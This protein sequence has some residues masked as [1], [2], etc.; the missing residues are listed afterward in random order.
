MKKESKNKV[1]NLHIIQDPIKKIPHSKIKAFTSN[2]SRNQN[3]RRVQTKPNSSF[4]AKTNRNEEKKVIKKFNSFTKISPFINKNINSKKDKSPKNSNSNKKIFSFKKKSSNN[5]VNTTLSKNKENEILNINNSLEKNSKNVKVFI[6]FRPSNDV[7]DSL[8]KNN[9]G[10]LVPKYFSEKQLGIYPTQ[11][12]STTSQCTIPKNLIFSFDK[13]FSPTS[14]Q[15]EI[16]SSVG[17][18]IVEDIMAGYNGTI[19]TYGQSGSGKTYT[20]YGE[21]IFNEN[22]KG[23]I[24]RIVSEI[25]NRMEK[26]EGDVDFTIKLSV[27]EIYKEILFDLFTQR[28]NLKIIENNDKI[29]IEN[30]TQIYI[31]NLEEFFIYTE[32]SQKNRKV[33]E[34]KLNHNSSRSHCIM[35]LEII[36]NFKKQ[37]IIKKGILNLVDLAGS[38]KVSKT[39]AVGETLEE[40]KKINLSLSTLGNVIHALSSKDPNTIGHIPY[41][42][43]KLT[44]ILK[45]SL[46]GNY[47]T[48]LIVTCSPHSYNLDEIISSLHF[49]KRVKCIKNDYKINIKYSYEEL[50]NLVDNLNKKLILANDNINRLLKGEKIDINIVKNDN[51]NKINYKCNNCDLLEK[52]KKNYEDKIQEL[53]DS[54]QEK[55]SQINKLKSEIG[56]LKNI[57]KTHKNNTKNKNYIIKSK[58]IIHS[59]NPI[60]TKEDELYDLYKKIKEILGKIE[61]ENER[62]K[63]IQKEEEEIRKIN[64]KKEQFSEIIRAFVKD[65]DKIKCFEKID[66]ITKISIPCVKEKEYKNLFNE[67]K[68]NINDIFADSVLKINSKINNNNI[69]YKNLFDIISSNLF[70]EYLHFYFSNQILNQGYLKLL[71]DNNSLQK[72]NKYLFTIIHDILSENYDI[73]NENALNLNAIKT[74]RASIADS[75]ITKQARNSTISE[76]NKKMVKVVSKQNLNFN[77][78]NSLRKSTIK[79]EDLRNSLFNNNNLN[80]DNSMMYLN[81]IKSQEYEKS[82]GK[83]KM[84]RNVVVNV[85]KETESIKN[86]IKEMKENLGLTIKS[87]MNYFC[88]KILKNNNVELDINNNLI[89]EKNNNEN[90]SALRKISKA[91]K[92]NKTYDC[93]N[94]NINPNSYIIN[95]NSRKIN[96]KKKL[97]N[98]IP[99]PKPIAKPKGDDYDIDTNYFNPSQN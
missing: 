40:A 12:S 67:F 93:N 6:R 26:I 74:L 73:A 44:R 61:E 2:I 22:S 21:D 99:I 60:K 32:L 53:I 78:I 90:N 28:N 83:F 16:Y 41:R 94:E 76:L 49:A 15:E 64:L 68:N 66:N 51:K 87:I 24:P 98:G 92:I 10:W 29:Y 1:N 95:H 3:I 86:D 14:T 4:N 9:Y 35:M 58:E 27:M 8:L 85:I 57:N 97:E 43:S 23:I 56:N 91:I 38:E 7:E 18:R 39:G 77:A 50:Q 96:S 52:E 70:M 62:I 69:N 72:M 34:T 30:L 47:K 20:M 31:S 88:Q 17:S 89:M 19:F 81:K 48:Y 84:I 25:F 59:I 46:G 13:I 33:A 36:Q 55:D 54:N 65:N 79:Y 11:T 37:K 5:S 75:F 42:D 82:E 45:E 80:G 63:I 71:L